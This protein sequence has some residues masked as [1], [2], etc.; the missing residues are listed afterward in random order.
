VG[1]RFVPEPRLCGLRRCGR[2]SSRSTVVLVLL[3]YFILPLV[4]NTLTEVEWEPCSPRTYVERRELGKAFTF[5]LT[6][7]ERGEMNR[8]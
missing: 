5:I 3:I 6:Q 7:E 2:E 8:M 4:D 1:H